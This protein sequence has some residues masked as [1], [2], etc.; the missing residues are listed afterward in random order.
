MNWRVRYCS[1]L[2]VVVALVSCVFGLIYCFIPR[3]MP[4]H[5]QFIGV[6][7]EEIGDFNPRLAQWVMFLIRIVGICFLSIGVLVIGI[8][9]KAFRR[10][11][12]WAWVTVFPAAMVVI[13]P[14]T[15]ITFYTGEAVKWVMTGL[16]V[17]SL[18]AMFLPIKDFFRRMGSGLDIK[19]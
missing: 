7:L 6:S 1:I 16:L 3:P 11:E 8:A 14:L 15:T 12:R 4:Y 19:T 18:I 2:L 13:I 9:L 5:L 17:L 10:S